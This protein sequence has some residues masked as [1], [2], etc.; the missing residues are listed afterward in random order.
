MSYLS[1]GQQTHSNL[2]VGIH[3]ILVPHLHKATS[4]L[5]SLN[6]YSVFLL[7]LFYL[8]YFQWESMTLSSKR[9]RSLAWKY[10][11]LRLV[12]IIAVNVQQIIFFFA[13]FIDAAYG[14]A[15]GS[16][17]EEEYVPWTTHTQ[18]Y[19]SYKTLLLSMVDTAHK[20]KSFEN[21]L[22][23]KTFLSV[24]SF[25]APEI[26]SFYQLWYTDINL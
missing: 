3:E 7:F 16:R 18:F 26:I 21:S 13:V 19:F 20:N 11:E 10:G 6:F 23:D 2:N 17:Y 12:I 9:G 25:S 5:K 14:L 4:G 15:Q 8:L 1:L 24:K 22:P